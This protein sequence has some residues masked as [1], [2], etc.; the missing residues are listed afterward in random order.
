[1]RSRA[2]ASNVRLCSTL[3][4]PKGVESWLEKRDF[5]QSRGGLLAF[6]VGL[7][8]PEPSAQAYSCV[9]LTCWCGSED[10]GSAGPKLPEED[11]VAD[12]SSLQDTCS[13]TN[14][15]FD[16]ECGPQQACCGGTCTWPS[17]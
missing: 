4:H 17:E 6:I 11:W 5:S 1:M 9:G 2:D 12:C 8:F 15:D 7:W 10:I 16:C 3:L 14:G 13:Q